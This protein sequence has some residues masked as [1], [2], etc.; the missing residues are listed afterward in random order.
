MSIQELFTH[1]ES[2]MG[3]G[4]FGEIITLTDAKI[5]GAYC[6]PGRDVEAWEVGII[7]TKKQA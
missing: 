7:A 1:S 4:W 2:Q 6:E 3:R 5:G